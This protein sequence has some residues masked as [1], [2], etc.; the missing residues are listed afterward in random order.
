V[1]DNSMTV[2]EAGLRGGM[3]RKAQNPDYAELGR[4][5]GSKTAKRGK[6]YYAAIGRIGGSTTRDRGADYQAMGRAGGAR[7]REL[8]RLGR[9]VD[10]AE[11]GAE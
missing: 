4:M 10:A 11:G 9:E 6:D 7:V 2:K 5:G 8:V 1:S 3:A